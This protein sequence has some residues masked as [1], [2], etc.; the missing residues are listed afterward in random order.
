VKDKVGD[1]AAFLTRMLHYV[2]SE[3]LEYLR[4]IGYFQRSQVLVLHYGRS[5]QTVYFTLL[6]EELLGCRKLCLTMLRL[7]LSY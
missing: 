2:V 7:P 4:E 6:W 1:I 5:P 3:T